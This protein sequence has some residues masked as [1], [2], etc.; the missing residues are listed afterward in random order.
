M[1]KTGKLETVFEKK[2]KQFKY[3]GPCL[4][5]LPNSQTEF[6]LYRVYGHL[7]LVIHGPNVRI[8]HGSIGHTRG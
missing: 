6:G 1:L 2:N 7:R 3:S 4:M 5:R 8:L